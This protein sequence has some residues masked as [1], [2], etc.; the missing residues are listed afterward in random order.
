[1]IISCRYFILDVSVIPRLS[2]YVLFHTSIHSY[3]VAWQQHSISD[4]QNYTSQLICQYNGIHTHFHLYL[5]NTNFPSAGIAQNFW[6]Q[7]GKCFSITSFSDAASFLYLLVK[8]KQMCSGSLG[9]QRVMTY[10]DC[11]TKQYIKL[12]FP[13]KC[14]PQ[15]SYA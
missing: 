14:T 10:A 7:N 6:R 2:E 4:A 3:S 15:L 12:N 11:R 5:D 1:M 13:P 8:S 9:T